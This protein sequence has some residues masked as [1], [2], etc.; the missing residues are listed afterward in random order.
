[1][2]VTPTEIEMFAVCVP[3]LEPVVAAELR[4][5]GG[6]PSGVESSGGIDGIRERTGG[7]EFKGDFTSLMRANLELRCVTRVLR[8]LA[9]F[10]VFHLAQLD[11]RSRRVEWAKILPGEGTVRVQASCRRSKIYHSGAAAQRVL[12]AITDQ[13]GL[14]GAGKSEPGDVS[15][16]VRIERDR[17]T[18]SLDSSGE[19]LYRRGLKPEVSAAPMRETLAA[20]LL[21][22]CGYTTEETLLD[23][24]CGS[25]TL[26]IEAALMALDWPP[27]GARLFSFMDWPHFDEAVWE[28]LARHRLALR[29]DES[30]AGLFA[31]DRSGGAV[32]TT[33]R[34]LEKAGLEG[35]V[36]LERI[37]LGELTRPADTGLLIC[38]PPYGKR[39]GKD[40]ALIDLYRQLGE[41]ARH[42]FQGWRMGLVTSQR[43]LARA[44]G[45]DFHQVS[46]PIAHGGMRVRLY[47]ATL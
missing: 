35:H 6:H 32:A 11:K 43:T 22:M 24:M 45:L 30:R 20:G 4:E 21:R 46:V 39:L 34:N 3:G 12:R 10:P 27:G 36:H 23:P 42:E 41:V 13:T 38:N 37:E 5:L 28:R 29:R 40:D 31:A 1:V 14:S 15:V 7:V 18:L 16:L 8:R 9:S 26:V 17:C 33:R 25:G 2:T 44:T 47:Q 19:P